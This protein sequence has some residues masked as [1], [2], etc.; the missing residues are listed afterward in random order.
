MS[1]AALR[2][3]FAREKARQRQ[4]R[5]AKRYKPP[6]EEQL[7]NFACALLQIFDAMGREVVKRALTEQPHRGIWLTRH[8]EMWEYAC[9]GNSAAEAMFQ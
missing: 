4:E 1:K 8:R 7:L 3:G 9:R 6:T 2:K 5:A